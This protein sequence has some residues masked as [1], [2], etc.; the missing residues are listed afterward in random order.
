[1]TWTNAFSAGACQVQLQANN[2][3]N[4]AP[5]W[6]GTLAKGG[7]HDVADIGENTLTVAVSSNGTVSLNSV[8]AVTG[9]TFNITVQPTDFGSSA[10]I[11]TV[12]L[13]TG[14]SDVITSGYYDE[15]GND[16]GVSLAIASPCTPN[17]SIFPSIPVT[18]PNAPDVLT[19]SI[20]INVT[21]S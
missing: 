10:R 11:S 17:P 15:A 4:V 12:F 8:Q 7:S 19:P 13:G 20:G 16:M 5:I 1:M 9:R 18:N 14:V 2:G 21:F 6:T 3:A